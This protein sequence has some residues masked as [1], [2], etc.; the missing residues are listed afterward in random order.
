M[1]KITG[2]KFLLL[3]LCAFIGLGMEGFYAFLL[4]PILYGAQ[5]QEW[6]T[7]QY[8]SH[9]ILT[10]ITWGIIATALVKVSKKR[11]QFD[12]FEHRKKVEIWQ[13]VCIA[14]CMVFLLVVSYNAWNGLKI[15]IE[16]QRNGF[17]IFIFQYIYYIF[18]TMLF[19]L[20]IVFGQKA[21]E[22]LL[23]KENFPYGAIAVALTW[24]LA[25][26]IT[27]GSLIIGLKCA[28]SGF[29]FGIVYLLV[30]RD[31]RKTYLILFFMFII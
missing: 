22:L 11:Y 20:I 14:V 27:K 26:A 4:E 2:F 12:L 30:N 21:F 13:W 3:A 5:A 23:K 18:E 19:T 31:I 29:I 15:V 25:H 9:W 8:I 16:F 10:C 1:K 6:T 28:L 7:F 17:L 24:G